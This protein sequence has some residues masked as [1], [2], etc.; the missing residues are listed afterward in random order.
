VQLQR[1][2]ETI[3]GQGLGLA[4]ISYDSVATLKAFA[5]R[6]GITFPL[7]S[8]EGSATIKAWGLL[9]EQAAG[10]SAGI[11]HPGTFV[12]DA[13][14]TVISRA[15]EQAYQERDTAA[16]ILA[17]LGSGPP[18]QGQ[19][20][21][22][23]YVTVR[24][25]ASDQTAAPG[26]RVTLLLDV[27]AGP[28][29]HVYAPGQAGY[30]PIELTLEGSADFRSAPVR[31]PAPKPYRFA[32][33]NETVQTYDG[34]FRLAQDVTLALTPALRQ[35]ANARETLTIRGTLDYQAC[36]DK[37]CYRP[38]RVAVTWTIGLAPLGRVP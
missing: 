30:V 23:Q 37:V 7:L 2:L 28:K 32:P 11:P 19:P 38:D 10:R 8:D 5:D 12:L 17:S 31:Y 14:G 20:I 27:T 3:K 18:A 22:A 9:N 34:A 1:T 33:L 16:S 13:R 15:F 29:M 21:A 6:Q 35:R 36:D 26:H 4:A 24:A 25:T